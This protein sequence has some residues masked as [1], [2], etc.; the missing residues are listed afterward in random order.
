[1]E[2]IS[3]H[4]PAGYRR[5]IGTPFLILA[6]FATIAQYTMLPLYIH[7]GHYSPRPF[8][9]ISNR[10]GRYGRPR[11]NTTTPGEGTGLC[12]VVDFFALAQLTLVFLVG[13]VSCHRC[14]LMFNFKIKYKKPYNLLVSTSYKASA[15]PF[16]NFLLSDFRPFARFILVFLAF[17]RFSSA[18]PF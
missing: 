17:A 6:T 14:K 15:C 7:I 4:T 18:F 11:L 9:S 1:M 10:P 3:E 2:G 12:G 13:G 5:R 16:L 8:R